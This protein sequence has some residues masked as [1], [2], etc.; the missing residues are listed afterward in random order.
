[1]LLPFLIFWV[2][3]FL[4]REELELRGIAIAVAVWLGL[5]VGFMVAGISPYLFVSAQA[6]LDVVLL[7]TIFGS[8]IKIR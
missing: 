7:L 4:G 3:I 6:V 2:L 8:D 5:L 1:M